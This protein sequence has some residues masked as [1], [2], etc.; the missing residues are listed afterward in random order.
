MNACCLGLG[1][2]LCVF[3]YWCCR[4]WH[5]GKESFIRCFK[6][7]KIHLGRAL[8]GRGWPTQEEEE[9]VGHLW[10]RV[11]GNGAGELRLG[12][13]HECITIDMGRR[14]A[15]GEVGRE[16]GVGVETVKHKRMQPNLPAQSHG[17]RESPQALEVGAF[18]CWRVAGPALSW[19]SSP[20]PGRPSSSLLLACFFACT[21]C[22]GFGFCKSACPR[23]GLIIAW[24]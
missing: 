13:G 5:G 6:R 20:F 9:R 15:S 24:L 3:L 8:V 7:S 14:V 10:E 21:A 2:L 4:R 1:L 16:G 18:A 19:S 22:F 12:I 11:E 23:H 17:A